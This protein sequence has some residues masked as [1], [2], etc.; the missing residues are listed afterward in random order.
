[1]LHLNIGKGKGKTSSAIGLGIRA[2]GRG[3]N[4]LMVQFL[5]CQETGEML[6]LQDCEKF[7][8]KRFESEHGFVIKPNAEQTEQ[9]QRE[10]NNAFEFAKSQVENENCDVLILDEVLDAVILGFLSDEQLISLVNIGKNNDVEFVFTGRSA[11]AELINFA[12]YVT[13]MTLVKHPFQKG[14]K[15]REGIEY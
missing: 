5:K 3:K 1:M 6:F 2:A 10:I 13:D 8:I 4:V 9:L 15:A 11:S 12:D 14:I 7:I